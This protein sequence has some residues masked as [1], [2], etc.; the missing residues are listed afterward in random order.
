[1]SSF[2]TSDTNEGKVTPI[3]STETIQSLMV[4]DKDETNNEFCAPCF[5][6]II[7]EE[8]KNDLDA[9]YS[10]LKFTPNEVEEKPKGPIHRIV[11][12]AD[13]VDIKPDDERIYIIGTRG[14]KV[15]KIMGLEG[16]LNL[17][18]LILRSC[19][20]G[21]MNGI[22]SLVSLTKLEL[23]DNH[24]EEL[25][26]LEFLSNLT[27]LDISFNSIRDMSPVAQCPHLQELYIAQNKLRKI[28]GLEKLSEL[29][30]L[31]LGANRIRS[32]DGIESLVSL[33]SMWLGKNK[34]ESIEH[35]GHLSKLRQL[36]VQNNRLTSL[37]N[38]LCKSTSL[39]E[40]YLACNAI[41][42]LAPSPA[43]TD[44]TSDISTDKVP[45]VEPTSYTN[46]NSNNLSL[47]IGLPVH[48]PLA[49]VDLSSNK[50]QSVAGI[51]A[52]RHLEE[53]WIS[54]CALD[55]FEQLVPL[56]ALPSLTCLYLEHSPLWSN[57]FYK[58]RVMEMLPELVQIDAEIVRR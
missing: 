25:D 30:I 2:E 43:A 54:G 23:Y 44:L 32:M 9:S 10:V 7:D 31:D 58:Q 36:D 5:P 17:K 38:D 11:I 33:E 20:I 50:L 41:E 48:S 1:M 4:N 51:D 53:L 21:N 35:V 12:P 39:T 24:I 34:I 16:M 22:E 49:I 29:R 57:T 13:V 14:E 46:T 55:S 40:L 15:T 47:G 26:G 45:Y 8:G 56:Q 3:P 42:W 19:L 6:V 27:I 28:E 37:G 52:C 18:E